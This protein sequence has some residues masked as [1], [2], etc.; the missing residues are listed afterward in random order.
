MS[1]EVHLSLQRVP[2]WVHFFVG[3]QRMTLGDVFI[4]LRIALGVVL[5]ESQSM[6]ATLKLANTCVHIQK[7]MG[8][9]GPA[10]GPRTM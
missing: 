5:V 7:T 2:F 1:L 4:A 3:E 9:T 10:F 6:G 8:S